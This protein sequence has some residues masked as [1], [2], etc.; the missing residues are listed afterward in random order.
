MLPCLKSSVNNHFLLSECRFELAQ[1][2]EEGGAHKG[3]LVFV[4][5]YLCDFKY[6][7]K[8]EKGDFFDFIAENVE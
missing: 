2:L 4:D 3:M 1:I 7:V 5:G 8:E 6:E